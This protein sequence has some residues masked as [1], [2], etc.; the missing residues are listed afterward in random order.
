MQKQTIPFRPVTLSDKL[1][2]ERY[3]APCDYRNCDLNFMNICSWLFLYGTELAIVD[4]WLVFRFH[5]H[6]HLA[7][8]M[9]IGK[10][11][12]SNIIKAIEADATAAEQP[13]LIIGACEFFV[14]RLEQAM[15]GKFHFANER[16]YS[17]YIYKRTDL[18]SL[19]GKHLQAKR[20][21][22][23]RFL[24]TYPNYEYRPLTADLIPLCLELEEQWIE[25]KEEMQ[26]D[27]NYNHEQKSMKYVFN[28]WQ[29]LDGL[30]GTL[31]VDKKLIAFTFGA[32]INNCTFDVCV[33]KADN[34]LIGAYALINRD[35]AAHIP[36]KY[37]WVNREEDLGI[38]GLRQA[39][40]SYHPAILLHKY[41]AFSKHFTL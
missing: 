39:K 2:I 11:N 25:T 35:F 40:L 34:S 6:G 13:L 24:H 22:V 15:P 7:Y 21:Y 37:T 29:E 3:T 23:N 17:D 16:D 1:L 33:E 31:F 20:N 12:L 14:E 9:P 18:A 26:N 38:P 8:M 41:S 4:E 27:T 5:T 32:P 10:G 30:G 28:H 19:A 36:E